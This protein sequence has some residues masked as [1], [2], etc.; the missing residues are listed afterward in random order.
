MTGANRGIGRAVTT[1]LVSARGWRVIAVCRDPREGEGLRRALATCPGEVRVVI[2]DLAGAR[3][4]RE[5]A[6]RIRA[7]CDRIDV[8][9]HNAGVWPAR[10][11]LVEGGVERAFAVNHLAPFLLNHELEPRLV[12]GGRIVQVSAGL[13]V[14]GR[15]DVERVW[16]GASFHPIRTYADTKLCNLLTLARFAERLRPRGIAIN[17]VHPGVIRTGL[18]D[19][20]GPLGLLLRLV[21]R[22]WA[23]PTDAVAP[24]VRLARDPALAGVSGRYYEIEQE[25]PLAPLAA[26]PVVADAVWRQARRLSGLDPLAAA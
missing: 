21:K 13:H 20:G 6:A 26:D 1:D 12:D 9:I 24:I 16:N 25:Q 10:R 5:A 22:G 17:A 23:D 15:A 4:A 7:A 18:G 2:G 3:V 8:L 11:E 14:K 19:R